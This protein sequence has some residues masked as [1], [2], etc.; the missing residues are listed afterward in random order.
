VDFCVFVKF[1]NF[2]YHVL[3]IWSY[4]ARNSICKLIIESLE[5]KFSRSKCYFEGSCPAEGLNVNSVILVLVSDVE[6]ESLLC[7]A[8]KNCEQHC[9]NRKCYK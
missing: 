8:S 3:F 9:K 2:S 5:F 6:I 4:V 1:I 7:Q